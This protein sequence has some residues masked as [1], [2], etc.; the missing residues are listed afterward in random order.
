M[1]GGSVAAGG[2]AGWVVASLFSCGFVV[3]CWSA[4]GVVG[5]VGAVVTV[6]TVDGETASCRSLRLWILMYNLL[7]TE[8]WDLLLLRE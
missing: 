6:F 1:V 7:R 2:G 5:V 3:V 8:S 4:A